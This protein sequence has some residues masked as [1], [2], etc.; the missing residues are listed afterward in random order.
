MTPQDLLDEI[1]DYVPPF[2]DEECEKKQ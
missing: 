1:M 2:E